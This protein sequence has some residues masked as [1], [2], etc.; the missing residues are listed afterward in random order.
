MQPIV[1][2]LARF[3][4]VV[5]GDGEAA[6]KRRTWLE[7]AGGKPRVF[8]SSALPNPADLASARLVFIADRHAPYAADLA[9]QARAHGALVH[10]EDDPAHSD[11]HMPAVLRRGDLTLAISTGGASPA[12]A[13]RLKGALAELFGPEWR[14]RTEE[15]ARLRRAWRDDGADNDTLKQRTEEWLDRQEWLAELSSHSP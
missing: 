10:V 8:S 5:I 3:E 15:I 4:P 9:A 6:A 13:V 12:L 11:F 2:D 7:E 14:G 1:L